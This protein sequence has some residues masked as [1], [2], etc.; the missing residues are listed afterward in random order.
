[1]TKD[2]RPSWHQRL[3]RSLHLSR[4][5]PESRYVQ[6]ATVGADHKPQNRTVVFRGFDT[7]GG[8]LRFIT[9]K[10][11]AKF[12]ALYNNPNAEICWY[13]SGSREQYRL[14][15]CCKFASEKE[16]NSVW[17]SL[18][19]SSKRQFLWGEPKSKLV[20]TYTPLSITDET[21]PAHF[22]LV[23]VVIE[24]V[25]YLNLKHGDQGYPHTREIY[26]KINNEWHCEK[27][28]P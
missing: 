9:D 27:V 12:T 22:V 26:L 1:M 7:N 14:S 25:D 21:P 10:R 5:K 17:K 15:G 16:K 28:I 23:N 6:L 20:D 24:N 13:F 2:V 3:S 18:S 4:S 11:S 19:E 8:A